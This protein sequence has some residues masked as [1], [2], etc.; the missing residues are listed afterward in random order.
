MDVHSNHKTVPKPGFE[1]IGEVNNVQDVRC[2]MVNTINS[3]SVAVDYSAM[4]E[5]GSPHLLRQ[6]V[7]GFLSL[8]GGE[9]QAWKESTGGRPCVH[10]LLF[11]FW[12]S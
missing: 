4:Q 10:A 12:D 9:F 2:T 11:Q 5:V 1:R 6:F 7:M 3:G 8:M